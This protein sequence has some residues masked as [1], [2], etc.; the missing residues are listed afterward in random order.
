MSEAGSLQSSVR[1]LRGGLAS[2]R[3]AAE[4]LQAFP[5][6]EPERRRRLLAV[7]V[8]EATRLTDDLL[9]LERAG[10]A[11]AA[12]AGREYGATALLELV[13]R[14]ATSSGLICELEGGPHEDGPLE[15][16]PREGGRVELAERPFT[17]AVAEFAH[18][19]RR[20]L[21][22]SRIVLGLRLEP[23]HLMLDIGWVPELETLELLPEW[24][25]QALQAGDEGLRP[26]ARDH[27]GEAWFVLDRDGAGAR[28]R[29]LFPLISP[30]AETVQAKQE[31]RD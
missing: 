26:M 21:H 7:V 28:V 29:L 6:M 2:L 31:E 14:S 13:H 17:R 16:D 10:S 25:R 15:G 18:S 3:A 11:A 20:D 30:P 12:G 19:L 27:D 23:E 24:Q 9:D 1:R 4:T 8:E 5:E 22:V